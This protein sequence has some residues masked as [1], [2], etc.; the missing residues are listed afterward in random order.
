M[1]LIGILDLYILV[2]STNIKNKN[3]KTIESVKKKNMALLYQVLEINIVL[4]LK[5]I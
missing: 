1:W 3:Q 4:I 2:Q 5:M